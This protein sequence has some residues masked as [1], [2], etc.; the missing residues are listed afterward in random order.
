MQ[1]PQVV[2]CA[3]DDWL[4]NQLRELVAERRWLLRE[5]RQPPAA[6]ELVRESRP[7]VLFV[8]ADPASDKLT[9][10]GVNLSTL[11]ATDFKFG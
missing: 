4:A 10:K 7:T 11:D 5:T 1:F 8:Q 3:F 2:V 9:L 6:L